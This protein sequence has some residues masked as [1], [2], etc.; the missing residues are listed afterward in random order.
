VTDTSL[1]RE[2]DFLLRSLDDLEEERAAGSI[3]DE[4]YRALHDDYTAR[5]AAVIRALRDGV[6]A[7]PA[8]PTPSPARRLAVVGGLVAFAVIAGVALAYA[9]GARLPG[10]T[11]SGNS[12]AAS[13]T[14]TAATQRTR[15][16]TAVRQH[17]DDVASRLLLARYLEADNDLPGALEQYDAV[18]RLD[19]SNAAAFAQSGRIL[20]LT[21]SQ[22]PASEA[23]D[24][25]DRAREQLD[26]SIDL[27]PD[28]ADPRFFRAI[29]RANEFGDFAGAQ[30]DLQRYLLAAPDGTFAD[31]ARQLLADVTNALESPPP[32]RAP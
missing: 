9:L 6:D 25:V 23:A 28:L 32:S 16:E 14:P 2:R 19:P 18:V 27:D 8:T 7:R 4:S 15:L 20:Y 17:P 30:S 5:A 3:D 31:Q 13:R 11:A 22:A 24:L 26:H 1:E 21:A 29:V 10:Q 12:S